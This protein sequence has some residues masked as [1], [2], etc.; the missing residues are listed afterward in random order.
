LILCSVLLVLQA[1]IFDCGSFDPFSLQQDG[2]TAS[3]VDVGGCEIAK[4]LVISLMVVVLD[5]RID[6][7]FEVAGQIVSDISTFETVLAD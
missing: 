1:T 2:L 5:E 3:E 6:F 7:D 4:A